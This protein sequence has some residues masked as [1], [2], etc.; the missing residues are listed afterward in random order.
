MASRRRSPT[1]RR[2]G[3]CLPVCAMPS[4]LPALS[5]PPPARRRVSA[6]A[7][8]STVPYVTTPCRPRQGRGPPRAA[9]PAAHAALS[10][11]STLASGSSGC[12]RARRWFPTARGGTALQAWSGSRGAW[13]PHG[14]ARRWRT[15][16]GASGAGRRILP[17]RAARAAPRAADR[18]RRDR[19]QR[20]PS[21]ELE[22]TGPGRHHTIIA[23]RSERRRA[24][25]KRGSLRISP[26]VGDLH[27]SRRSLR[28]GNSPLNAGGQHCEGLSGRS[29]GLPGH[30]TLPLRMERS[31]RPK[32]A[33]AR[34][35]AGRPPD[36]G[37]G[38]R[39]VRLRRLVFQPDVSQP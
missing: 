1:D 12:R 14:S 20:H 17:R 24:G 21:E 7:R 23:T 34:C 27:Q 39:R 25:K 33:A 19:P 38:D 28:H 2:A 6:G 18:G 3:S 35:V 29:N 8:S 10:V 30:R 13:T 32:S 4:P 36:L 15:S 26:A 5:P 16:R 37:C 11:I 9:R 22:L 31:R